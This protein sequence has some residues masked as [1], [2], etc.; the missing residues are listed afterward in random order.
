VLDG[1]PLALHSN[2]DPVFLPLCRTT[3][4]TGATLCHLQCPWTASASKS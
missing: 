1:F 4:K 3:R 2:Y